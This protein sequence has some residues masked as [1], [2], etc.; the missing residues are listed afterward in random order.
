M[1]NEKERGLLGDIVMREF[2]AYATALT[3]AGYDWA[4]VWAADWTETAFPEEGVLWRLRGRF[5]LARECAGMIGCRFTDDEIT[6][7][8]R[9]RLAYLQ[10][11]PDGPPSLT[12]G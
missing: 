7:F 12:E 3:E 10:L 8:G 9:E 11:C 2:T 4:A 1:S 6:Q 5:L